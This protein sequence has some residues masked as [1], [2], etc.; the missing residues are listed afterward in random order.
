MKLNIRL[1]GRK[2]ADATLT[3]G[4]LTETPR[5]ASFTRGLRKNG[6]WIIGGVLLFTLFV[7]ITAPTRA[8]AWRIG[9]EIKKR[10]YQIEVEDVSMSLFGGLALENVRWTFTPSRPGQVPQQFVA[11][12]LEVDVAVLKL[13]FGIYDV[14]V[15]GSIDEGTLEANFTQGG[16]ESTFTVELSN[17]PLYAVPKATQALN[18]P[19]MGT[20]AMKVDLTMPDGKFAMTKG[21]VEVSCSECRVGDGE[22]LLFVPGAR[23]LLAKGITV[24]EIDLGSLSGR[25]VFENGVGTTDGAIEAESDDVHLTIN[26]TIDLKDPFSKSRFN[27]VMKLEIS[28]ALQNQADSIRLMVQTAP[29]SQRLA[30]PEKGLGFKLTGPLSKPRFRGINSKSREE[31]LRERRDKARKRAEARARKKKE[32]AKKKKEREEAEAEQE[33]EEESSEEGGEV[34]PAVGEPAKIEPIDPDSA[35]PA[36]PSEVPILTAEGEGEPDEAGGAGGGSGGSS[37]PGGQAGGSG[38][39]PERETDG[40]RPAPII[41]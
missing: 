40:S 13:L 12:E 30:A 31:V 3:G 38:G 36:I 1:P 34:K 24:P 18:A 10:G 35:P 39:Q 11:E 8:I 28:E 14:D 15:T 5:L 21:V 6:A 26:G 32:R 22:T 29:K 7:W 25:I 33:S 17:L 16:D 20:V 37:Q 2:T 23:G 9:H 19:L 27:L 4:L 41:Q